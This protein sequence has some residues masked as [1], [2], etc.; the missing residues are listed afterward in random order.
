[1]VRPTAEA[2]NIAIEVNADGRAMLTLGDADR[3]RQA[4]WNVLSNAIKFTDSGGTV[5]IRLE[6]TDGSARVQ[7]TDTGIGI[8]EDLLPHVFDRFRQGEPAPR[9]SARERA[10]ASVVRSAE[11][12]KKID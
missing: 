11:A 1:M 4:V 9:L 8:P 12:R 2:K 5:T 7:V 3:L 10:V 6:R